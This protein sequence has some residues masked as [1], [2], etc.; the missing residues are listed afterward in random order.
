MSSNRNGR[1]MLAVV[2][3]V[4]L[5]AMGAVTAGCG[6]TGNQAPVT[7]TTPT[8]T[9]SSPNSVPASPTEKGI[10]PT[11]GNLFSPQVLAPPAPTEPPGIHRKK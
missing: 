9:T 11:G 8:T 10:S 4:A 3:G 7:S 6:N 1:R 2:G 5:F